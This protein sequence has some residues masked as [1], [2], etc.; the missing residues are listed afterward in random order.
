M[1]RQWRGLFFLVSVLSYL[2]LNSFAMTIKHLLIPALLLIAAATQ[3]QKNFSYS[4]EKPKPGDEITITYE[5]A[6]DLANNI[7]PVEGVVYQTGNGM[8]KADD[9]VMQ[10]KGKKFTGTVKTD[11]AAAFVYFG[12]SI[13]KKFDN[14]FNDG[15]YIQLYNNDKPRAASHFG[16]SNL[17]QYMG[18]QVGIDP[19]N[20]KALAAMEKEFELYPESKKTYLTGYVRLQTL[21][22]KDD[23]QK[24][25]QKEIESILKAGLKEETDYSTLEGLYAIA[26]LPEQQKF[27]TNLK[28]EK[29]PNGKWV[30]SDALQKYNMEKDVE[31]KKE[32]LKEIVAKSETDP[33]WKGIKQSLAFYKTMVPRAY[34]TNK[35]YENFKK[36]IAELNIEKSELAGLY[37]NAAWEMQKTSDNLPLAE[38]MSKFATEYYKNEWKNPTGKKPD[39]MT[40]KQWETN[41]KYT[42]AMY[43]DTYGMVLYRKG[44]FKK[45]L[46]YAKDAALIV[47]EGKDPEQNNTYALIAE[48]ALSKK[49]YVKE[50]EQFVKDGKSTSDIKDILKRAYVKD[51]K[52]ENGFDEYI[53]ALQKEATLKMLEELKKSM[54]NE[55]AP[56]FALVD[57][58]GKKI[59]L[60]DLKGK[61]VVVDF[62]AT[63]CGPCIASF[64]GMQK[65]VTK[66]KED[67]N[68]KFVFIDT[69]ERGD[70]KAKN[71]SEFMTKNKYSFHVLMDNDD[72]VVAEFK[73]EGI[74]TKFVIDKNGMIRFKSV[75]YDGSDDKLMTELTAMIEMAS[76]EGELKAF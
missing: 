23:A 75:G 56:V 76:K 45:A 41:N 44:E 30:V 25:A 70:E 6:G 21:V 13:D 59:N 29:F 52:S 27:I 62:W 35:D 7:K 9:I 49:Q 61:V 10:R 74:P 24:I 73:V 48:K 66:F 3:A 11:T 34:L 31:K 18:R 38:E 42:Y 60:S 51:K 5:P 28:K 54:L 15:Y 33:N 68:V 14:N 1:L 47:N 22:K 46:A 39:Y 57:L 43:A 37:N 20:E 63:W 69:W 67:P 72:K 17:Y 16:L 71:A 4:P 32:L 2:S 55:K 36:S 64:P 53:T 50:L 40:Q 58:E 12:F 26:K 19:N 8:N 65:M